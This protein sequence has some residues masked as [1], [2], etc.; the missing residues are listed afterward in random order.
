MRKLTFRLC[1][2][3]DRLMSG[4]TRPNGTWLAQ[5]S[6]MKCLSLRGTQCDMPGRHARRF[7][8]TKSPY[9]G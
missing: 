4:I 3:I 1:F 6:E 9:L 5:D 7:F 2:I 8:A